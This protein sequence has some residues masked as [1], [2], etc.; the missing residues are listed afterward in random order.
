MAFATHGEDDDVLSEIN[1][2]P[3][4]DVML[5]LLVAFIVTAPLLTN[6]VKVNLPK[7]AAT[8]PPAQ[9]KALTVSI[10]EGGS[11]FVD[12]QRLPLETVEA[13]LKAHK[14]NDAD[15]TLNLQADE[16]VPYGVVAKVMAAIERAGIS[17]L[18]VLTAPH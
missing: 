3:L 12:K 14:A 5:V 6:A 4:V 18:S 2:T 7:T 8:A 1:I 16:A 17:R 15:L 9:K 11:V 13:E 10:D